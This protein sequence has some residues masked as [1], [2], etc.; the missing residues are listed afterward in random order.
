MGKRE[1]E[2]IAEVID[3][4][5]PNEG[6]YTTR[7][8]QAFARKH[9]A[10]FAVSTPS[11]TMALFLSMK[12]LGVKHGD[13]V[14][15]PDM[16]FIA[17]ANAVEMCGAKPVLV[18]IDPARL[19]ISPEAIEKSITDKTVGIT[20]VH[21][22]GRAADMTQVMDIASNH[23]LWVVEDAAEAILSYHNGKALG[24]FGKTG[25][26]SFS[27][28]KTITTGQGGM[29]LTNDEALCG[30]LRELKDQGRPTRG[31]GGDDMHNVIGYNAKLT[32]LQGAMGLAQLE[33]L[34]N[35][36]ERMRRT[37]KIYHD[38]L[39]NIKKITLLP[40]NLNGK[41]TPQWTDVLIDNRDE[42]VMHL[43]EQ[44]ID[45]RNFW[46]PI[47]RQ[48]PYHLPDNAFPNSTRL[49]TS[50]VWLSSA[51]IMDDDD[52]NHICNQIIAFYKKF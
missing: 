12:A 33:R 29:I 13:E 16:T 5:F 14:I 48:K 39:A 32:N 3:A 19:T 9:G 43:K 40:F 41:E 51:F 27:P 23:D 46:V 47:H 34:D 6:E 38:R 20:P 11:G 25:C 15:V 44:N 45:C 52:I 42:L 35:R 37:C 4:Q 28:F 24:T 17:T 30:R 22:S 31:T 36:V 8:E 26:F 10:K 50:A 49:A 7:F 1:K 21:V 2:L 18:D